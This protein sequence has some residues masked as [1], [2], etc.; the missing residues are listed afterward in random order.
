MTPDPPIEITRESRGAWTLVRVKGDVDLATAPRLEEL[1]ES[2]SGPLALDLARVR[3][4]DSSGLRALLHLHEVREGFVIVE[5]SGVVK[6]LFA[7]T[8]MSAI[9]TIVDGLEALESVT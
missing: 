6:R 3:F 8:K 1:S 7:L 2:C 4:M 9:F 5:P